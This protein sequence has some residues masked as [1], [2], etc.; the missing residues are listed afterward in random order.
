MIKK[1]MK[2]LSIAMF[3]VALASWQFA[4]AAA[5]MPGMD[6]SKMGHDMPPV[7]QDD[8]GEMDHSK[9][10]HGATPDNQASPMSATP[11]PASSEARDPHAYSGGYNT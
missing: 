8:M 11:T 6:H 5:D 10:N 4:I 1:S 7:E 9:M 3:S 2:M